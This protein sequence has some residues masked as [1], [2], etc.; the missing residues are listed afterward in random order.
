[1]KKQFIFFVLLT[2]AFFQ[3]AAVVQAH[4]NDAPEAPPSLYVHGEAVIEAPADQMQLTVG[5][6]T[7]AEWAEAAMA[8]N[9]AKMTGVISALQQLGLT[10]EEYKTGNF[11]VQP[12]WS[13]RPRTAEHDWKPTIAGYTVNN[14]LTIT[15]A[16]LNLAGRIIEVSTKAGANQVEALSFDLADPMALRARAI[17][18]ATANAMADA[19]ILATTA[20]VSLVR[21]LSM[22]LENATLIPCRVEGQQ[23][24]ERHQAM[25]ASAPPPLVSGNIS[26]RAGVGIVYEIGLPNP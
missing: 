2:L 24:G 19:R 22:R 7:Q 11:R 14:S 16:K 20:K 12:Q 3:A 6:V 5:V 10:T 23:F 1:M 4:D 13:P 26:V 8:Q 15:T 21:V 25:A 9:S 18:Q 17:E